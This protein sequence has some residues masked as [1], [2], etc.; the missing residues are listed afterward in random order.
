MTKYI[1]KNQS[2]YTKLVENLD[3]MNFKDNKFL[4][5]WHRILDENSTIRLFSCFNSCVDFLNYIKDEDIENLS[6][7]EIIMENQLQKLYFD[8]DIKLE[9]FV[10]KVNQDIKQFKNE[11]ISILVDNIILRYKQL[12]LDIDITKNILIFSSSSKDK[13]SYHVIVDGYCVT[14]NKENK[15][16]YELVTSNIPLKYRQFIDDSMFSTKQ[17]FRLYL[18]Q[19]PK[20]GRKKR[21]KKKW[22]Y[23]DKIINYDFGINDDI[24]PKVLFSSLFQSSCV[25]VTTGCKVFTIENEEMDLKPRVDLAPVDNHKEILNMLKDSEYSYILNVYKFYQVINNYICL[26]RKMNAYCT[27]CCR[28]HESENAYMMVINNNVY[29]V[30][31]RE[32]E[33]SLKILTLPSKVDIK[34]LYPVLYGKK[35]PC[36]LSVYERVMKNTDC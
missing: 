14:N 16:L 34:D 15:K 3:N 30:C 29:F 13:K 5:C 17:Q 9:D 28:V 21:F 22:K 4:V 33:K 10:Q 8:I 20:S 11:L 18:S 7:F 6:F 27:I 26:K 35:L 23:H 1:Y 12:S 2:W 36:A 25:S 32:P 24:D 19:K 31:R